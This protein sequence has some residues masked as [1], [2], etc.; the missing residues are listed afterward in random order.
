MIALAVKHGATQ[1]GSD[2]FD[3]CPA[4]LRFAEKQ[5]FILDRH[6]YQATIDLHTFETQKFAGSS[7]EKIEI[8]ALVD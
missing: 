7:G 4:C 2:V 1:L 8:N 5:G 3:N 6:I